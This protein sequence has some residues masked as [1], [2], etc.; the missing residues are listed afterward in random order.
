MSA[1]L[2]LHHRV[3]RHLHRHIGHTIHALIHH[4]ETME[5]TLLGIAFA[6]GFST[7]SSFAG[8]TIQISET[9]ELIYPLK[10]VTTLP[11]RAQMK[12][13]SDLD[14]SCKITLP[15]IL[16]ANYVAFSGA[17]VDKDTSYM[18]IYTTLWG[19]SYKGQRDMDKGDHAGVDIATA[20]GTP[21]YAIAHGLVTFAGEQT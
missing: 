12:L 6:I 17:K 15:T 20:K 5:F 10:Q 18:S 11:C 2:S 1:P 16:K 4:I 8:T 7:I 3:H 14:A 9:K 21:L 13:W 19:A